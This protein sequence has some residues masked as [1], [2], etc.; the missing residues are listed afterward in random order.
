M[1][2]LVTCWALK[3]V[4]TAISGGV[5]ILEFLG[6]HLLQQMS[7][8][9][10]SQKLLQRLVSQKLTIYTSVFDLFLTQGIMAL[11][12]KRCTPDNFES[13]NSLKVSFR[14]IQGLYSNFVECESFLQSN[15]SDILAL[16][17]RNFLWEVIFLESESFLLLIC[18]V[19]Q[20]M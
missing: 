2:V 17:E 7:S 6:C 8:Q 1:V 3:C 13:H 11:L 15:S 16:C 18:M 4:P 14:N 9:W 10:G 20:F 12:S 5:G 19:L